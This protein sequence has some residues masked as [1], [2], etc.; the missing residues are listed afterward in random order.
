[1]L[2]GRRSALPAPSM[3]LSA[4]W[5]HLGSCEHNHPVLGPSQA[6][7]AVMPM[8]CAW[9]SAG[10][11]AP[12]RRP[13]GAMQ[14]QLRPRHHP[15]PAPPALGLPTLVPAAPPFSGPVPGILPPMRSSLPAHWN[16]PP[17]KYCAGSR[18]HLRVP[19]YSIFLSSHSRGRWLFQSSQPCWCFRES[20]ALGLCDFS[21][22][23][24]G[25]RLPVPAGAG[26]APRVRPAQGLRWSG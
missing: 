8:A 1:M 14:T 25:L 12:A 11:E 10:P 23:Q 17:W 26:P 24:D 21:E 13:A 4:H 7:P 6:A 3:C 19:P 2:L 5:H 9:P 15:L 20:H 22:K 16:C 18:D